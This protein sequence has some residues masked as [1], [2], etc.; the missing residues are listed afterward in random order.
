[1]AFPPISNYPSA[2]DTNYNLFLVYNSTQSRTCTDNSPWAQEVDIVPVAATQLE[3]WPDNGFANIDGELFYYDS[4]DKDVNGKVYRLKEC[5]RNLGGTQT[6]FNHKGTWVRGYIVAEHHN[7]LANT[8][9]NI[10]NFVGSNFD[11]RQ[12]TLDWRIRNLEALEPIFDDFGCPEIDF[13][14]IQVSNDPVTGI[15]YSY[16][17][18]ITPPG[19]ISSF[20]LDFGDGQFTTTDLSGTHRY[21]LNSTIDPVVTCSNNQCQVI[22]TPIERTNPVEPPFVVTPTFELPF[23]TT[24]TIPDFTIVP[25]TVPEPELNIPPLVTPC[26]SS[27]GSPSVITGPNIEMVSHVL[28]EGPS[29]PVQIL[30]SLVTITG[31]DIP[32]V[33]F[34]DIPPTIVIDPPI[35]PTIVIIPESSITMAL[36]FDDMPN[37]KV[38]WGTPPPVSFNLTTVRPV[39][40]PTPMSP[41]AFGLTNEFGE[42][43]ADI[44]AASNQMKVEY[45]TVD[46]PTEIKMIA[47]ESIK[48]DTGSLP[49][50]IQLELSKADIPESIKLIGPDNPIPTEIN[51]FGPTI[52]D[53]IE[54]LG[55]SEIKIVGAENIV[56]KIELELVS[57]LPSKIM[58][59]MVEPL[60]S[61]LYLDAS[62]VP[63]TIEVVGF[64]DG[65]KL[66]PP[67]EPVKLVYEGGPIEMKLVMDQ[68]P[69]GES[70]QKGPCFMFVPCNR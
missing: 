28:I 65:I 31:P 10:E 36:N 32:S 30:Y 24:P 46:F 51:I 1:M 29:N 12:E 43:F 69:T 47:P 62:G 13:T 35:P 58:I 57:E 23:P 48:L 40:N 50:K 6:K 5:A 63:K 4:V 17:L 68:L 52:P 42:E 66:L 8:I 37:F 20:R 41:Q 18:Q 38:D 22:Q 25:C 54:F 2:I 45:E 70:D 26:V 11:T 15:V 55:P 53:Q 60:P 7:Q 44:F 21:A 56:P 3:I 59:E 67:I 61:T 9:M 14:F 39:K 33:I 34:V 64:P 49:T 16:N 19:S 27:T